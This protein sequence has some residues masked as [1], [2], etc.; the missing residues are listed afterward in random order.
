[1]ARQTTNMEIFK[2][3]FVAIRTFQFL[4]ELH[5]LGVELKWADFIP[6]TVWIGQCFARKAEFEAEIV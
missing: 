6:L 3:P 4:H 5:V 1:M 2:E